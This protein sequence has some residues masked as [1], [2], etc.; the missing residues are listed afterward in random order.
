VI[1][2]ITALAEGP[3]TP[4]DPTEMPF[5]SHES[6]AATLDVFEYASHTHDL[7]RVIGEPTALMN[8]DRNEILA[9]LEASL[10]V[11]NNRIAFAYPRGQY[12]AEVVEAL[13]EGGIKIAFNV[14]QGYVTGSS[15]PMSLDRFTVYNTTPLETFISTVEGTRGVGRQSSAWTQVTAREYR[16]FL[17][18]RE[19]ED[20]TIVTM[21]GAY[22]PIKYAGIGRAIVDDGLARIYLYD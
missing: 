14:R 2:S 22:I 8:A 18:D 21:N 16:I 7:H 4:F 13:K 9:D 17:N 11:V 19:T 10:R 15:N 5:I 3:Q 20:S 1:F 12:N 6:M